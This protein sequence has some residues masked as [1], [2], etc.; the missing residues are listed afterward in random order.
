V[1]C[2]SAFS[3][4]LYFLSLKFFFSFSFPH[5]R[6][7]CH[8][9]IYSFSNREL[10]SEADLIFCPYNYLL[11]PI[12]RTSMEV[13]LEG[14]VVVFDEVSLLMVFVSIVVQ[15]RRRGS[16]ENSFYKGYN[17]AILSVLLV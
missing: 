8:N 6:C 1:S 15:E 5:P 7:S 12:V 2:F 14:A 16:A 10:A 4:S 17:C 11:D 9:N 13:D 3:S